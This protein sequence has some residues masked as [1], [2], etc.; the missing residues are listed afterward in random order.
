[1]PGIF[2]AIC[3]CVAIPAY[4]GQP[5]V[6]AWGAIQKSFELTRGNRWWL[7]LIGIVLFF[8]YMIIAGTLGVAIVGIAMTSGDIHQMNSLPVQ[9]ANAFV[10]G[11]TNLLG[12]IFAAATYVTLRESKEKLAP[13]NAAEVFS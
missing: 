8:A 6:G 9:I 4:V 12:Y 5:G 2:L 13:D 1:I 7:L 3:L 11:I 10:S